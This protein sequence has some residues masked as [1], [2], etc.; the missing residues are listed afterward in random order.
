MSVTPSGLKTRYPGLATITDAAL[1][2]AIDD[3]ELCHNTCAWGSKS[4]LALGLLAAH[5]AT[6]D[7]QV[8]SGA[9]GA[10]RAPAEVQAGTQ[11]VRFTGTSGIT[12]DESYLLS[13]PYGARY[14]ALMPTVGGPRAI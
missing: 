4:D 10:G 1:Q 13:T 2:L 8:T 12:L 11:R 7:D 5:I 6:L 3:A 9:A 14:L